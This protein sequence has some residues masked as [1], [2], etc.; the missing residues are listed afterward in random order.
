[1]KEAMRY[2]MQMVPLADRDLVREE[3]QYQHD[4]YGKIYESEVEDYV[5]RLQRSG[6]VY[7]VPYPQSSAILY[8]HGRVEEELN[9]AYCDIETKA[10]TDFIEKNGRGP[11]N[12]MEIDEIA[13]QVANHIRHIISNST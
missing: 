4:M 9:S 11:R 8:L 3:L 5:S 13:V 1:M 6:D 2:I 12:M 10:I 7:P